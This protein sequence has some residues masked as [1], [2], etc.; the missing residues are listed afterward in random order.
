MTIN[1]AKAQNKKSRAGVMLFSTSLS[2]RVYDRKHKKSPEQ[3]RRKTCRVVVVVVYLSELF[4][5]LISNHGIEHRNQIYLKDHSFF[6][7][8]SLQIWFVPPSACIG[9]H[10]FA[11]PPFVV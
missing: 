11:F 3:I 5:R 6:R 7:S 2:L 1:W 4:S 9:L 8:I 10:L